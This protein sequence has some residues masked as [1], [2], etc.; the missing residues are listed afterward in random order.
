MFSP[1]LGEEHPPPAGVAA[2][3]ESKRD[4]GALFSHGQG[5]FTFMSVPKPPSHTRF[6]TKREDLHHP[7]LLKPPAGGVR[8]PPRP[9]GS[10]PTPLPRL[11]CSS[12]AGKW[13]L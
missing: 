2:R 7:V 3:M 4:M 10:P 1:L 12:G 11:S 8:H 9:G 5:V 13:L 6:A